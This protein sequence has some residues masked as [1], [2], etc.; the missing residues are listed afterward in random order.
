MGN[1]QGAPGI[2]SSATVE[3]QCAYCR[4]GESDLESIPRNTVAF[5]SKVELEDLYEGGLVEYE[6]VMA[7][8]VTDP[9]TD[10]AVLAS[11]TGLIGKSRDQDIEVQTPRG[12]R[13]YLVRKLVTIHELLA[14]ENT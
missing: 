10:F 11:G 8:E 6:I 9:V 12:R 4:A 13:A 1:G 7:G 3:S 14:A 2:S 5:G